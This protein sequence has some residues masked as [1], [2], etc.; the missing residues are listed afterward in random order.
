MHGA[1]FAEKLK[2]EEEVTTVDQED[3]RE[4]LVD[5]DIN[6]I[7][8]FREVFR[9]DKDRKIIIIRNKVAKDNYNYQNKGELLARVKPIKVDKQIINQLI[10]TARITSKVGAQVFITELEE[11]V[12]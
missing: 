6:T 9:S 2:L 7:T 10:T 11:V 3:M 1:S 8:R 5:N 12:N 4:G